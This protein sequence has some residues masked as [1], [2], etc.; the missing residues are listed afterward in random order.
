MQHK[1]AMIILSILVISAA[2]SCSAANNPETA[3]LEFLKALQSGRM[4]EASEYATD[5]LAETLGSF[6]AWLKDK[7][8][9]SSISS[10]SEITVTGSEID[11]TK[12]VVSV[13]IDKRETELCLVK[14]GKRWKVDFSYE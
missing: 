1:Q 2:A 8:G 14:I 11:N 4:H 10:V 7:T 9:D 12:A 5:D 3:A 13:S 6:S